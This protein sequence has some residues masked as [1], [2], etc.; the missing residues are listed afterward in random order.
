MQ[1]KTLYNYHGLYGPTLNEKGLGYMRS[2]SNAET[3][4]YIMVLKTGILHN[5]SVHYITS[6]YINVYMREF[7]CSCMVRHMY[8]THN[9]HEHVHLE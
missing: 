1:P 8:A 3:K 6:D 2:L 5:C 4:M 7:S 9:M